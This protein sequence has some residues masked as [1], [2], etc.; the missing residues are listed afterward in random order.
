[1]KFVILLLSVGLVLAQ[2]KQKRERVVE[3]LC[4]IR[5]DVTEAF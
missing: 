1:M 3:Y 2:G 5:S 4:E